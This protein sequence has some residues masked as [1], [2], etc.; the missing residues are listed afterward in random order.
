MKK[1]MA[2]L[3]VFLFIATAAYITSCKGKDKEVKASGSADSMQ[4]VLD[5]GKY[6]AENVAGCFDCHSKRDFTKYSGPPTPGTELGGGMLFDQHFGIPG[7]IYSRNITPDNETGIGTW[8]D[9]EII[10]AMTQG[11][12]KNGDTLFPLMP[13]VNFNHMA[14]SDLLSIIAFLRTVKPI[15]NKVPARQ[16]PFPIS[17][18]YPGPKALQ[19]SVDMNVLPPESD[20]VAYG[21]YLVNLA[22]CGTCHSPLTKDGPDRTREYA[23]GYMFE[24]PTNKVQS[25]NIT[26]DSATGIG[27]WTE[28]RFLNKFTPYRE[29]KNYNYDPGHE[30]TIMPLS[31]LAGMTDSDLKAVYAYIRTI[32]PISNKVEKFP[33]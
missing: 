9:D 15:K 21:A 32:K 19:A 33:K 8:T 23:G 18:A 29:E 12:N 22:D 2:I 30:N 17:M 11:I 3:V 1:F 7:M 13:Y 27:T 26:S 14:K 10:R 28:E 4:K 20:K 16:L 24:L 5:R 6:L 31:L 25:A